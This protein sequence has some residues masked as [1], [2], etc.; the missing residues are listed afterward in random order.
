MVMKENHLSNSQLSIWQIEKGCV[1]HNNLLAYQF[2][3]GSN[4]IVV[5]K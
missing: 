5:E 3:I 1:F 4:E 2:F